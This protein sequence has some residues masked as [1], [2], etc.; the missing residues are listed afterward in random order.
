MRGEHHDHVAA[1]LLRCCF[2]EAQRLDIF[3]ELGEKAK[4]QFGSALFTTAEHDRDFDL[5]A[6]LQEPLDVTLLGLV[7]VRI[8][9]RAELH[10]LNDRVRLVTP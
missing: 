10:F 3:G 2:D 1:V 7:V 5:V 8:D 6:R 9:L 4:T